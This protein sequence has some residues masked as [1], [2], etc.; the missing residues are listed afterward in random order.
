MNEGVVYVSEAAR[1]LG[2]SAHYLRLL[3]M[4]R[5]VP[6]A[7]RDA[8]GARIYSDVDLAFL[9]NLGIGLRPRRL[10]RPEEIFGVVR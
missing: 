7:R 6:P 10:K 8:F 1:R 3:E 5:R 4:Q 9:R 2:V